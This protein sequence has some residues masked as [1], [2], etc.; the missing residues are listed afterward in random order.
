MQ[1]YKIGVVVT[2]INGSERLYKMIESMRTA[3]DEYLKLVVIDDGSTEREIQVIREL[4]RYYKI[5]LRE[6]L[7]N[8]GISASWN[9][10]IAY[11]RDNGCTL[12]VV[13]NDDIRVVP[14]WLKAI[15]YFYEHNP[16]TGMVGL[17]AT[18]DGKLVCTDGGVKKFEGEV[19]FSRPHRGLCP[20]GFC[21]GVPIGLWERCGFFDEQYISFYEE[22]DLGT[23]MAEGGLLSTT[24]R[25]P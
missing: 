5:E 21:F 9:H 8:Q 11:L 4:C 16:V 6:H 25:G 18:V 15:E 17:H 12:A 10:G 24:S 22:V 13:C 7:R 1:T 23:A 14:G 2:T 19:D 20:N 3:K